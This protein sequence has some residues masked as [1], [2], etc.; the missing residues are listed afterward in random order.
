MQKTIH[1]IFFFL[2]TST[3]LLAQ[4]FSTSTTYTTLQGRSTTEIPPSIEVV[5]NTAAPLRLGWERISANIPDGWSIVVCDKKCY[6]TLIDKKTFTL[7]P[8]EKLEDFRVSF[9]PNGI[10][11]VGTVE[12][13]VYNVNNPSESTTV[14]FS[15]SAQS[16]S[17]FGSPSATERNSEEPTI[18]PN[19]ATEHIMVQDNYSEVRYIEVFNVVGRKITDFSV[20][21]DGEKYNISELPRGMYM[22][23]LL[24]RN[25]NIIRTQ[26]ISKYNP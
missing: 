9:R 13:K 11:G 17:M 20:R 7:L 15:G 10:R 23:R 5:N 3:M 4:N 19:P 25:R 22:V 24:D 6:S 16:S 26:R 14:M 2:L 1:T 18:F 8:G 21:H 12:V